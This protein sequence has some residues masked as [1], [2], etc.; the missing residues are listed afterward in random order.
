MGLNIQN[1]EAFVQ[2]FLKTHFEPQILDLTERIKKMWEGGNLSHNNEDT[3]GHLDAWRTLT[4]KALLSILDH[5]VDI[6]DNPLQV[7]VLTHLSQYGLDDIAYVR[8]PNVTLVAS[9]RFPDFNPTKWEICPFKK[10]S[11]QLVQKFAEE[12]LGIMEE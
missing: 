12:L 4:K 8:Q 5:L 1:K 11:T 7:D 6:W 2:D 10:T 9:I 3:Q